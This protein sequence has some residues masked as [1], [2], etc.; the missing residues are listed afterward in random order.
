MKSFRSSRARVDF[1][2]SF[3][4]LATKIEAFRLSQ[5]LRSLLV[6]SAY[7]GEGR[8]TATV[9]LGIALAESGRSVL[10]VDSDLRHPQ[11]NALFGLD[12]GVALQ[13][14]LSNVKVAMESEQE[15]TSKT[16]VPGLRVMT[17][18]PLHPRDSLPPFS[19]LFPLLAKQSEDYILFD[20]PACVNYG[21]AFH[22]VPWVDGILFVVQKRRHD[23]GLQQRIQA[24]IEQLG[25]N[26]VGVLFNEG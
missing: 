22:L 2:E 26:L 7:P 10:V 21:D 23:P 13:D 15:L 9:N 25:G 16:E 5:A 4:L 17:G 3:R 6:M 18:L 8:T 20:S 14:I 24:Q 19:L 1:V 12:S 11:M